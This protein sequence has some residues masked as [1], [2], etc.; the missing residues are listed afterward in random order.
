[1]DRIDRQIKSHGHI[2]YVIRL[3]TLVTILITIL[4]IFR[5]V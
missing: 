5:V 3:G 2:G 4:K 1:M